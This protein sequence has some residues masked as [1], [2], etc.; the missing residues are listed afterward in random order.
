[1][2][3]GVGEHRKI[4]F[5][6]HW[7]CHVIPVENMEIIDLFFSVMFYAVGYSL[8]YS[9]AVLLICSI[10]WFDIYLENRFLKKNETKEIVGIVLDNDEENKIQQD[11]VDEIF[12]DHY[13]P[14]VHKFRRYIT[15]WMQWWWKSKHE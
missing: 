1:V 6:F 15:G 2:C 14:P 5:L 7:F 4:E 11:D 10:R 3:G 9:V 8:L 12:L 13:E